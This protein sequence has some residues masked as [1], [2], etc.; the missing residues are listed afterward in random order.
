[1]DPTSNAF[2][3]L[4]AFIPIIV[5]FGAGTILSFCRID[6]NTE[7]A[8]VVHCGSMVVVFFL[9]ALYGL[10]HV[11]TVNAADVLQLF[12]GKNFAVLIWQMFIMAA[13]VM[14]GIMFA[15]LLSTLP[16]VAGVIMG[17]VL[18]AILWALYIAVAW[19]IRVV[20]LLAQLGRHLLSR[21]HNQT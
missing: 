2:S 3:M 10:M 13:I 4:F 15:M 12:D 7:K 14:T 19:I 1:M 17:I 8:Q 9:W 11:H 5:G 16:Y 18:S 6:P 21:P 20:S